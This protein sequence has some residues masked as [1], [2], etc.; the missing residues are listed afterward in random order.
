[1]KKDL[2][3][4]HWLGAPVRHCP[5][6]FIA[7]LEKRFDVVDCQQDTAILSEKSVRY[8]F[9][10]YRPQYEQCLSSA[11][12][13][14]KNLDKHLIVIHTNELG[15]SNFDVPSIVETYQFNPRTALEWLNK[16][17]V[18]YFWDLS[19]HPG[20]RAFEGEIDIDISPA[21]FYVSENIQK[22]IREE[23]AA[24]LCHYSV[25]YFSK[26]FSK[27]VGMCFRDYV[28]HQRI[29]M[30]KRMLAASSD[31]KIAYIAY[32]C[33]YQDVSYFSRIF[34]KKTGTTP[35]AYRQNY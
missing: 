6:Y 24:A 14:C 17:E 19:A 9:F 3:T 31:T 7:M 4:V 29:D 34:K 10:F 26:V 11:V 35:G 23:A 20:L 18:S 22:E 21:L 1:M 28:T 2:A 33:G 25:T 13:M 16:I 32:S 15:C 27:K 30:A 12:L 5:P 8:C